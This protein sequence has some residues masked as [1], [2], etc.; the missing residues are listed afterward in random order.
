[1][2]V[3]MMCVAA[4]HAVTPQ[5]V[6]QVRKASIHLLYA[7]PS[8]FSPER[9]RPFVPSR[10]STAVCVCLFLLLYYFVQQP[11]RCSSDRTFN[12]FTR[13]SGKR[14]HDCVS[15]N[16]NPSSSGSDSDGEDFAGL[17]AP[18]LL[19]PMLKRAK[20]CSFSPTSST[21]REFSIT[22]SI[23]TNC[24]NNCTPRQ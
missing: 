23:T 17:G 15:S 14:A 20:A 6:L 2:C 1:M 21:A 24:E 3:N 11:V 10:L 4:R 13:G 7:C 9:C 5:R 8:C 19:P 16:Q 18:P 12:H 22:K